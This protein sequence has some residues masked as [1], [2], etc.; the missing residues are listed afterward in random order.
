MRPKVLGQALKHVQGFLAELH[1]VSGV[2]PELSIEVKISSGRTSP[3]FVPC[4]F[5][6]KS[7]KSWG[8]CWPVYVHVWNDHENH[9]WICTIAFVHMV[10]NS[11]PW[12]YKLS[13]HQS[14][15][16]VYMYSLP[17]NLISC[18]LCPSRSHVQTMVL[19]HISRWMGT[20]TPPC[21]H[22]VFYSREAFNCGWRAHD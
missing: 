13:S 4:M 5:S 18:I 9:C 3:D 1:S 8:F 14:I 22:D 7:W 21:A 2:A 11:L 19:C 10:T 17:Q 20:S 12:A 6:A 15:Y 16:G